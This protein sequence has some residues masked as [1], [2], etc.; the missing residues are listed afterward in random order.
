MANALDL[1]VFNKKTFDITMED[2]TKINIKKPSQ[3]LVIDMMLMENLDKGNPIEIMEGLAS[4][5]LKILNNNTNTIEFTL[6]QVKKMDLFMLQAIVKSYG[7]FINELQNNP[8]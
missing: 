6:E 7:E 8:N 4:I 1:S 5:V 2:G 3:Q